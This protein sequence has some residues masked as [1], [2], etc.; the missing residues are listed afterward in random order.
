MK[1]NKCFRD[2]TG[3][4]DRKVIIIG[5]PLSAIIVSIM[6]FN[7]QYTNG[8]WAFLSLCIPISFVYTSAF[9]ATLRWFYIKIKIKYPEANEIGKRVMA[10]SI[11]LVLNFMAVNFVLDRIVDYAVPEHNTFRPNVGMEFLA[12]LLLSSLI[13]CM[14]EAISF[15]L[16]LQVTIAEK[17]DLQNKH[18]QSQLE[19]LRN[20]VN[21]HFLFNSLNTL[22]YLIPENSEKAVNF[23]QKLSKVYRCVLESRDANVIALCDELE[24][25]NAYIYLL[26]ERFG[27]NLVV[28]IHALEKLKEAKIVPLTLQILFENAIKHNVISHD[29]PLKIEIFYENNHLV[30]RNT[31]QKKNQVMDSTGVGLENIRERY[32]LLTDS[33][34]EVIVSQ[35]YFTVLIPMQ[36]ISIDQLSIPQL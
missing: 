16:K 33:E 1:R 3:F 34:I 2:V 4:D 13:I 26:R 24:Y 10:L 31:L 30:V 21:P 27:E 28:D 9:W 11:I 6:L 14:Y 25:L 35:Q 5:V 12:T 19:G 15:Y 22:T 20:Q 36:K 18:I 8:D 7:E 17:S 32:R 23:V 29:K